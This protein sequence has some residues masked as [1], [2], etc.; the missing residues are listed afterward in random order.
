MLFTHNRN[1]FSTV[2]SKLRKA[3]ASKLLLAAIASATLLTSGLATATVDLFGRTLY[4]HEYSFSCL[5]NDTI[6]VPARRLGHTI[7][8][9]V[10][11]STIYQIDRCINGNGR[12]GS[13]TS[14]ASELMAI[15]VVL[16]INLDNHEKLDRWVANG[17]SGGPG[18]PKIEMSNLNWLKSGKYGFG[19]GIACQAYLAN[20]PYTISYTNSLEIG[21]NYNRTA[22]DQS[23]KRRGWYVYHSYPL[24]NVFGLPEER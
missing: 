16:Q 22:K 3:C 20:A 21:W 18:T 14:Y 23:G 6:C 24:A 11:K 15:G 12:L 7:E 10:N 5:F 19:T 9:H 17:G 4:E 2:V 1:S 13:L 8:R